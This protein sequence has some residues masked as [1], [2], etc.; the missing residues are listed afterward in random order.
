MFNSDSITINGQV[1]FLFCFGQWICLGILFWLSGFDVSLLYAL[2][3]GIN[4]GFC[5]LMN[6]YFA[7]FIQMV[8][9]P[10]PFL[11]L[12]TNNLMSLLVNNQLA[13]QRVLF[14]FS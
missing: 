4:N 6:V 10:S 2:V 12:H 14:L 7:A 5:V 3:S 9:V 1:I 13:F 8:V 11:H